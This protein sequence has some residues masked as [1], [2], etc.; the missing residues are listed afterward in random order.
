MVPHSLLEMLLKGRGNRLV[1]AVS[2]VFTVKRFGLLQPCFGQLS[3]MP[4]V[5]MTHETVRFVVSFH[6]PLEEFLGCMV[7]VEM[8]GL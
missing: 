6:L 4:V 8:L 3:C 2:E 5:C 1:T 7:M